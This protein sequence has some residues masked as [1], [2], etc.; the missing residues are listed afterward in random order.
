MTMC[1]L[2]KLMCR[3]AEGGGGGWKNNVTLDEC[4][5]IYG[6]FLKLSFLCYLEISKEERGCVYLT[7]CVLD[8]H[9]TCQCH[10]ACGDLLFEV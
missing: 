1:M 2:F 4:S 7:I 9:G 8:I 10:V 3:L 5:L 6:K